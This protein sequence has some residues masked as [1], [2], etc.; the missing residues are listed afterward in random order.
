MVLAFLGS[1]FGLS[2]LIT[3]VMNAC[4]HQHLLEKSTLSMYLGA[5]PLLYQQDNAAVHTG[6]AIA[7]SFLHNRVE[8][9][10]WLLQS[11]D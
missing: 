2:V 8:E 7:Q 5:T 9:L 4:T 11:C 3:G 6:R 1:G 10:A